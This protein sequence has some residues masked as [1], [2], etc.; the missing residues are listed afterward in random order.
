MLLGIDD[1]PLPLHTSGSGDKRTHS[2]TLSAAFAGGFG[3]LTGALR[4]RVS[5]CSKDGKPKGYW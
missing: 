5:L 1:V 3:G 2:K 4:R